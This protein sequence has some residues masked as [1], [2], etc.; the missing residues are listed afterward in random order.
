MIQQNR[1]VQQFIS[2]VQVDS[3]TKH[4]QAISQVLKDKFAALGLEVQEDDSMA[5][6]GHG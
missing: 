3:E 2:L 4:E 5:K 1:L 6:S